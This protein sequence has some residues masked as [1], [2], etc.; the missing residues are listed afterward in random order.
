MLDKKIYHELI[1]GIHDEFKNEN[2]GHDI[3]HFYRVASLAAYLSEKESGDYD[4]CQLAAWTH[5]LG[6]IHEKKTG[7]LHFAQKQIKRIESILL[8]NKVPVS[9]VEQV[10]ICVREHENY[11]F[12]GDPK[13]STQE[14]AILQDADRLDALGAFGLTRTILFSKAHGSKIWSDTYR[15]ETWDNTDSGGS[16]AGH[17]Q[18]KLLRLADNMNTETGRVLGVRRSVILRAFIQGLEEEVGIVANTP[19]SYLQTKEHD[20]YLF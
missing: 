12:S 3:S 10:S 9:I 7:E 15:E 19:L 18:A 2:T 1:Q 13:P 20:D 17:I 4:I 14:S 6:R 16:T 11:Q 8:S 5:D